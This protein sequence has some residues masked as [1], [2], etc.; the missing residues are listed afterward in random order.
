MKLTV[1]GK[2]RRLAFWRKRAPVPP[3][4]LRDTYLHPLP[5][6]AG[7]TYRIRATSPSGHVSEYIFSPRSL[8]LRPITLDIDAPGFISVTDEDGNEL[9]TLT[10]EF[11]DDERDE[12]RYRANWSD[13]YM[14]DPAP[15]D[16]AD[17][18]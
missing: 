1:N 15:D 9:L 4:D 10:D 3:V 8:A 6:F 16:S 11:D 7:S 18:G 12:A 14:D 2:V 17:V 13:F 5:F